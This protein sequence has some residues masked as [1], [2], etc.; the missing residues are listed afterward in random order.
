[1]CQILNC[2]L[3]NLNNN[4]KEKNLGIPGWLS[5]LAPASGPGHDPGVPPQAPCMKSASP[6]ACVFA[7]LSVCLS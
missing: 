2:V 1:M 5:G 4:I 6:S 3:L 7:P